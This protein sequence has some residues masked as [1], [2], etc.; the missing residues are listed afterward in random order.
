[1]ITLFNVFVLC[2]FLMCFVVLH[3]IYSVDN[4]MLVICR[5]PIVD[6]VACNVLPCTIYHNYIYNVLDYQEQYVDV[7]SNRHV[8]IF[9]PIRN[10]HNYNSLHIR[11]YHRCWCILLELL[12][13]VD[14][15]IYETENIIR[16]VS[17]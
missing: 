6:G 11:H 2:D 13:V 3:D 7:M 14:L 16:L 12:C 10:Y 1:M 9:D 15:Q 5:I 17:G 8:R 4:G